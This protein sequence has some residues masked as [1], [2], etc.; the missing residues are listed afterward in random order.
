MN[1]DA[2]K[3]KDKEI[4]KLQNLV[5]SQDVMIQKLRRVEKERT[6]SE[7]GIN[8]KK[9]NNGYV[10]TSSTALWERYPSDPDYG[11]DAWNLVYIVIEEEPRMLLS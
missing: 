1:E 7:R 11:F 3:E 9:H 4:E 8:E 6:C 10:V 2:L 5:R